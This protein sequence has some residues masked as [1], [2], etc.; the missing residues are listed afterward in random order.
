[1]KEKFSRFTNKI[2][3]PMCVIMI[4]TSIFRGYINMIPYFY[5]LPI[6]ILLLFGA[7]AIVILGI[8]KPKDKRHKG[9]QKEKNI[10]DYFYS[11]SD[12]IIQNVFCWYLV[13]YIVLELDKVSIIFSY[14][15]LLIFGIYYGYRIAKIAHIRYE[16]RRKKQ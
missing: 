8:I 2:I 9:F 16:S 4:F 1:M 11:N 12:L 10:V 5:L 15:M 3:L 6:R 14:L 7:I 13:L